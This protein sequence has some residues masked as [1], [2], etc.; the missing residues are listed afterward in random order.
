MMIVIANNDNTNDNNN[1]RFPSHDELGTCRTSVI[2]DGKNR[3]RGHTVRE[4]QHSNGKIAYR[5][6]QMKAMHVV[7]THKTSIAADL[8][9]VRRHSVGLHHVPDHCW[10]PPQEQQGRAPGAII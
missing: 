1:K 6:G 4:T 5:R 2:R 3:Y 8:I 10:G 9:E 7:S